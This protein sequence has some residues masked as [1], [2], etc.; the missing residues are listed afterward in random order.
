V[1]LHPALRICT[2]YHAVVCTKSPAHNKPTE[3]C[4]QSCMAMFSF[5]MGPTR[6]RGVPVGQSVAL[7][8]PSGGGKSSVVAL[9]ERFYDVARGTRVGGWGLV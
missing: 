1:S 7:V 3:A 8:G 5:R 9:L 4:V 2:H 6:D